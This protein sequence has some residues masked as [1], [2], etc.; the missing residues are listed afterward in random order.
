MSNDPVRFEGV[1]VAAKANIYFEGKVVSHVVEFPDGSKKTLGLI[2]PGEFR[3]DTGAPEVMEIVAGTAL[4][5]MGEDAQWKPYAAGTSFEVP[6]DSSFE[7]K[8]E[9]GIAE[10]VCSYG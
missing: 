3:F 2:F 4:V 9:D 1:S 8:V 5:R 7:I 10:Y 6:G